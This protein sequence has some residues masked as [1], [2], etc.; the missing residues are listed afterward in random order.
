MA[1]LTVEIT[2]STGTTER[3]ELDRDSVSIGSAANNVLVLAEEHVA[4][5]HAR[6]AR[7]GNGFSIEDVGPRRTWLV[8]EG[9]R[10]AVTEPLELE[11]GDELEIGGQ[12]LNGTR[13]R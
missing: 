1:A 3:R 7:G 12:G 6:I 4:A 2:A 9:E 10:V 11:P 8:R 13:L 5:A